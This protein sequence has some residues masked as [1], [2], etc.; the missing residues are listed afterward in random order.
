MTPTT[1]VPRSSPWR[2][3]VAPLAVRL[4]VPAL[5]LFAGFCLVPPRAAAQVSPDYVQTGARV[6]YEFAS[7]IDGPRVRQSARVESVGPAGLV[8]H[9][10]DSGAAVT[11]PVE[12]LRSL[13]VATGRSG[14]PVP[15]VLLLGTGGCVALA[16]ALIASDEFE[17]SGEQAAAGCGIGLAAGIGAGLFVGSAA[18]PRTWREVDLEAMRG[19]GGVAVGVRLP[20]P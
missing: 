17:T 10:D 1:S 18:R 16:S 13:E 6:R 7:A 2:P 4:A 15:Y 12:T 20:G 14:T 8:V 9:P 19:A 5:A 11:I 3:E